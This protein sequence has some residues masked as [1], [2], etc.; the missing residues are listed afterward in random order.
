MEALKQSSEFMAALKAYNRV[1]IE[2]KDL[3]AVCSKLAKEKKASEEVVKAHM[4]RADC[5]KIELPSGSIICKE[6]KTKTPVNQAYIK[7]RLTDFF[8]GNEDDTN[9]VLD[10]I[11]RD[12]DE[13]TRHVLKHSVAKRKAGDELRM[14]D[15]DGSCDELD[16]AH[17]YHA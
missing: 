15:D 16:D 7:G 5:G 1:S 12:R 14:D 4:L 9:E 11:F 13:V 17:G 8:K 3:K 10:A 6:T 2:L